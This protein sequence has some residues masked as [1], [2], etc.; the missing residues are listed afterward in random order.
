MSA[1][2]FE[3]WS[4]TPQTVAVL[5]LNYNGKTHLDTCLSSVLSQTGQ[6]DHV[7]VVDNGSTDGSAE[8]V[9]QHYSAVRVI[10]F[11]RNLGFAE[12]YNRAVA[13]IEADF[14]VLLNNDVQVEQGWLTE[15][16][17][18][19]EQ[20]RGRVAACGSKLLFYHDRSLINHAGGR[21]CPIG[22][23]I[24]LDFMKPEKPG[25]RAQRFVGCV[26]GASMIVPREVFLK[27]G[28]FDSDFFAYFEDVDFCWRAW[29]RGYTVA[30]VPSSRVYHKLGATMGFPSPE[31]VFLG[32]RNRLQSMLKNLECRNAILGLFVSAAYNLVR[33]VRFLRSHK[34]K[35]VL[36]I[37][38]ADRWT[39]G[40]LG[41]IIMK[42]RRV[43]QDRHVRDR[44]LV[45][46]RL[47]TSF[48]EGLRE[49]LRLGVLRDP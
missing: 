26:S 9:A 28:G 1:V 27:L 25:V 40:H 11:E 29:L 14:V 22:G 37:L 7:Y 17:S 15:L 31:R 6:H 23:G 45:E 48:H 20:A 2:R 10:R 41:R 3:E 16:R 36:A 43:Q 5:V 19:L 30:Y 4:R 32:E 49:F 18:A 44:V 42:R 24:D 12:A 39:L 13:G 8:Y 34:P 38:R 33:I 21:L 35:V 46:R 47:M